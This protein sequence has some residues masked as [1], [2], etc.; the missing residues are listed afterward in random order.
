MAG[1]KYRQF[2]YHLIYFNFE[3]FLSDLFLSDVFKSIFSRLVSHRKIV[4]IYLNSSRQNLSNDLS[5]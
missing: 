1:R 2:I 4:E 3:F 5:I